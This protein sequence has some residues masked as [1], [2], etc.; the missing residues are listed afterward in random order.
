[1]ANPAVEKMKGLALRYG[2][3][4]AVGISALLFLTFLILAAVKPTIDTTPKEVEDLASAASSNLQRQQDEATIVEKLDSDGMVPQDFDKKVTELATKKVDTEKVALVRPFVRTEPGAGLIRGEVKD[5]LPT[6]ESL[7]VTAGRGGASFFKRDA[8]GDVIPAKQDQPKSQTGNSPAGVR[9]GLGAASSSNSASNDLAK[10]AAEK[11]ADRQRRRTGDAVV[12]AVDKKEDEPEDKAKKEDEEREKANAYETETKGIRYAAIVGLIKHKPFR[13][14]MAKALRLDFNQAHPDYARVELERQT[15]DPVLAKWSDW[16][17][18]DHAKSDEIRDNA[19][20]SEED[21]EE[22]TLAESRLEPL[23]SFLPYLT[24]GYWN[25]VHHG[26]VIDQEKLDALQKKADDT[27][28]SAAASGGSKPGQSGNP[29]GSMMG[30]GGGYPG[31]SGSGG[32]DGDFGGR[33]GGMMSGGGMAGMMPGGGGGRGYPGMGGA[34]GGMGGGGGASTVEFTSEADTLLIRALDLTVDQDTSYRYRARVVVKNPNFERDD[35]APGVD[36]SNPE[37]FGPW[38]EATAAVNVPED[39]TPYAMSP[40]RDAGGNTSADQVNFDIVAWNPTTGATI[41][42]AFT[43]APGEFVGRSADALVPIE[44]DDKPKNMLVNFNSRQLLVDSIGGLEPVNSLGL[45]GPPLEVP[46]LALLLRPDGSVSI[47]SQ[48]NDA[49]NDQRRF[50]RETYALAT[51]D[52][53]KDKSQGS[54]M[55]LSGSGGGGQGGGAMMGGRQ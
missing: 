40:G 50:A 20:A 51:S 16:A 5:F 48:S 32:S 46:A 27:V 43:A 45:V 22:L 7:F 33:G 44:A 1:M 55:G 42:K 17:P 11:A 52:Q 23:V 2:D 47:R 18:V 26:G 53:K 36:N 6:P 35:I 37:F 30:S 31:M 13:E 9:G 29:Y 12:G 21:K 41:V 3:K 25:G 28:A 14:K 4:I 10:Q 39:V 8:N 38:S 34:M 19:A 24:S 54:M 49:S 15:Y